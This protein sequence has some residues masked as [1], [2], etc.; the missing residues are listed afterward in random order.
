VP[1]H[2]K[3]TATPDLPKELVNSLG[4]KLVLVPKGT[5]WMGDRGEQRQVEI[6]HDFYM[7]VFPLT[8]E[9]W[10]TV[11]GSNP[12]YF[13]R[14]GGGDDRV[15]AISDADFK[16]FPVEQVSWDDV[17]GFLK[18]LNAREK[19]SGFLYRLP[20]EAEWEYACRGG[21][22]SQIDCAFDF[23]F[24]QP[25]NDLAPW[26][27]NFGGH[28]GLTTKVGSYKPNRLGLYDMHG[29]VWEWCQD[30]FQAGGSARVIR[31]GSWSHGGSYCR[32]SSRGSDEPDYR[33][34]LLGFRIT[35]VPSGE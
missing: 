34:K 15:F 35:A 31:G 17:Q 19:E 16:Q 6:P 30:L 13:S 20:T 3:V 32:A 9:Q 26:Q 23:Y 7:G 28:L 8:Q 22:S 1:A 12:S 4:R 2:P 10:Q 25:S 27:A 33:G 24:S 29:N 18:R 5:F 21:T 11:M 14:S